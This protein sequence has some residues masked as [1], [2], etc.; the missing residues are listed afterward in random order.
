MPQVSRCCQSST[1]SESIEQTAARMPRGEE[2]AMQ[3]PRN[4]HWVLMLA[5]TLVAAASSASAA[6]DLYD[7]AAQHA[8]RSAEDLRRDGLDHSVELLR[9]AG[10]RSG[11]R[12]LDMLAGDGYYS[13]LM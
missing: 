10:I 9:L 12:V 5:L 11:Q 2:I 1:C 7:A 4:T 6:A 13:E 8:G 3:Q